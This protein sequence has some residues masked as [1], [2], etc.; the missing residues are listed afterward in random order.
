MLANF[1]VINL[2]KWKRTGGSTITSIWNWWVWCSIMVCC[3]C[4]NIISCTCSNNIK[5]LAHAQTY[6]IK[7]PTCSLHTA[8]RSCLKLIVSATE[9][10]YIPLRTATEV[11]GSSHYY[12]TTKKSILLFARSLNRWR[13]TNLPALPLLCLAAALLTHTASRQANWWAAS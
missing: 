11:S 4:S 1:Q 10:S 9:T 2:V 3:T 13:T 5:S 12:N 6:T 8:T 7:S